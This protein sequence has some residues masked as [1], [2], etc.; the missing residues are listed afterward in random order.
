MIRD[1]YRKVNY[2][3]AQR[4]G[5]WTIDQGVC[6]LLDIEPGNPG[7]DEGSSYSPEI[8]KRYFDL[9]ETVRVAL[10]HGELSEKKLK[11]KD[12]LDKSYPAVKATEFI[13][14]AAEKG[15][16]VP[17]ELGHLVDHPVENFN[18][19]GNVDLEHAPKLLKV[20]VD[21]WQRIW[22]DMELD[23]N[24][25]QKNIIPWI[26]DTYSISEREAKAIDQIIRDKAAK[27]GARKVKSQ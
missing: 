17:D 22:V 5:L 19:P 6:Y 15:Y 26:K 3:E 12:V 7:T 14:W 20:A 10:A 24:S 23:P 11:K 4:R 21:A 18:R 25:G 16:S 1:E 13:Q 2:E 8:S 9:L 27:A